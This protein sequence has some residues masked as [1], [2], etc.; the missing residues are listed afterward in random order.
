M[1]GFG[2]AAAT[3][4]TGGGGLFGQLSER[5]EGAVASAGTLMYVMWAVV[6]GIVIAVVLLIVDY[7]VPFLPYNPVSGP[8]AIARAGQT[9]WK[10]SSADAENLVVPASLSP[11]TMPGQYSVSVQLAISDSRSPSVGKFRHILHRGSNPV[12]LSS[13]TAASTGHANIQASDLPQ[14]GEPTYTAQGLPQIMNPGIFLDS[15]KNDIHIFVHTKG[16]EASP[17]SNRRPGGRIP[18]A[19]SEIEVL[20]LESMTIQDVPMNT[21]IT[22]GVVCTGKSL[23]VYVNCR[24][25]ST[26][27]LRGIPYLPAADNQWFGR[28]GA[29]PFLGK[30]QN[31][32]LWPSNL[33]SSD[34][35]AMCRQ[36][37]NLDDMPQ[38]CP[39]GAP[40]PAS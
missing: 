24:L 38:S 18:G 36:G 12:G 9:F 34:Y 40:A 33:G 14:P 23:E 30:I 39:S 15:Y 5:F 8:S 29:F 32:T 37:G 22:I 27:L 21:P 6:L 11:T 2:G 3:S 1:S 10:T 25:Y 28:Y 4:E 31:L 16:K 17:V 7:F 20:W 26:M 13:T 19:I 35:I